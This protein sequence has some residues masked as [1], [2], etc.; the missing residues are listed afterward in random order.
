[1]AEFVMKDL[2][3]KAGL[4]Q[5]FSIASAATSTEDIGHPVYP[6]ARRILE[7]H[8][9]F[10][11]GKLARLMQ[12]RDYQ[13]YDYL[14]GMDRYN[15]HNMNRI[16]RG[17]PQK[18]IHLL[19]DYTDQ[20]RDVEDPWY[21]DD[22]ESTWRDINRGCRGFLNSILAE[23]KDFGENRKEGTCKAQ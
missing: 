16:C 5:Q 21:T 15:L 19:L 22:F 20:P 6:P 7:K 17:D 10:C 9:I 12:Q 18:K 8:G 11:T 4:A 3:E 13:E 14:I 23:R 2:V 1:M